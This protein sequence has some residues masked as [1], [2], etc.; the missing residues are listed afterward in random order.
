MPYLVVVDVW[1]ASGQRAEDRN[2][3]G[4]PVAAWWLAVVATWGLYWVATVARI[5]DQ[6]SRTAAV[7]FTTQGLLT[8]GC[9]LLA[10]GVIHRI[11]RWQTA[12]R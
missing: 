7:L 12:A 10:V 1:R 2:V 9:A 3:G 6:G 8:I 5:G 11:T 4:G